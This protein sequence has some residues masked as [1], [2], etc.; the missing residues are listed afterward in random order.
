VGV[1]TGKLHSHRAFSFTA[2]RF[3]YTTHIKTRQQT[4]THR[5]ISHTTRKATQPHR[6]TTIANFWCWRL[7]LGCLEA[8]DRQDCTLQAHCQPDSRSALHLSLATRA[9]AHI[10]P[11]INTRT[12]PPLRQL[13]PS[14][15]QSG[16]SATLKTPPTPTQ[17]LPNLTAATAATWISSWRPHSQQT[18]ITHYPSQQ[19]S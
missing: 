4:L 12:T 2:R 1:C 7:S 16:R 11:N 13:S 18:P 8:G 10:H 9:R 5:S 3:Q 14:S 6:K 17:R 15:T 19:Q